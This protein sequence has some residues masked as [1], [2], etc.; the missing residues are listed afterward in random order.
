MTIR[1]VQKLLREEGI[2][3]VAARGEVSVE[4]E[5]EVDEATQS[6]PEPI[7]PVAA[8]QHRPTPQEEPQA[9]DAT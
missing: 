4:D 2:R 1:G 5:R 8:P 7:A 3:E 9:Q 6:N